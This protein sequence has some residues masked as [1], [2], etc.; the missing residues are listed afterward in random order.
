VFFFAIVGWVGLKIE[1]FIANGADSI[2]GRKFES[3]THT[4]T[5]WESIETGVDGSIVENLSV[6][7][8]TLFHLPDWVFELWMIESFRMPAAV[9]LAKAVTLTVVSNGVWVKL[10]FSF[11]GQNEIHIPFRDLPGI[12]DIHQFDKGFVSPGIPPE[13]LIVFDIALRPANGF[14]FNFR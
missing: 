1:L 7:F 8:E 11:N 5:N 3:L 14:L 9:P 10:A 6:V 4:I 13:K 2:D 12:V